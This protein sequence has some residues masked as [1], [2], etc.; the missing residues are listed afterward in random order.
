VTYNEAR[1]ILGVILDGSHSRAFLR[2]PMNSFEYL[3]TSKL[4]LLIQSTHSALFVLISSPKLSFIVVILL[5]NIEICRSVFMNDFELQ[6]NLRFRSNLTVYLFIADCNASHRE[7]TWQYLYN[8]MDI[9]WREAATTP[10]GSANLIQDSL[11]NMPRLSIGKAL[12]ILLSCE[13]RDFNLALSKQHEYS[14]N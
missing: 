12:L 8:K 6:L 1:K 4:N 3:I 5:E 13:E 14:G 11:D 2:C 10:S 7:H 9:K